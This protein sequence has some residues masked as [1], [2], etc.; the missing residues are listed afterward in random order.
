MP[1]LSCTLPLPEISSKCS[2]PSK[3]L[4]VT[5]NTTN[6][7]S[8]PKKHLSKR[9]K[10]RG[11]MLQLDSHD[12]QVAHRREMS[13][14]PYPDFMS[15]SNDSLHSNIANSPEIRCPLCDDIIPARYLG[16]HLHDDHAKRASEL[17]IVAGN[18]VCLA[19]K[20][21][22]CVYRESKRSRHWHCLCGR[23]LARFRQAQHHIPR[24]TLAQEAPLS[25]CAPLLNLLA[26]ARQIDSGLP[27]STPTPSHHA[28]QP[29]SPLTAQISPVAGTFAP[30]ENV[31]PPIEYDTSSHLSDCSA[32]E[33]M[34]AGVYSA[35]SV[36]SLP[37][38]SWNI[39]STPLTSSIQP[40]DDTSTKSCFDL[41][42]EPEFICL[43]EMSR[44]SLVEVHGH[45][46]TNKTSHVQLEYKGQ[47]EIKSEY[48]SNR[49]ER[50]FSSPPPLAVFPPPPQPQAQYIPHDLPALTHSHA[51]YVPTDQQD[52][53]MLQSSTETFKVDLMLWIN[54]T[55]KQQH[56]QQ[57]QFPKTRTWTVPITVSQT[58]IVENV[59]AYVARLVK[60]SSSTHQAGVS[61]SQ[62]SFLHTPP[63]SPA[64]GQFPAI[65]TSSM[66]PDVQIWKWNSEQP[67]LLDA[68]CCILQAGV[69]RGQWLLATVLTF[70]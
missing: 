23:N 66:P 33:E 17:L 70:C 29:L 34:F 8:N 7:R 4:Q 11:Q 45:S 12:P 65:G 50:I 20:W 26:T 49:N 3:T 22:P 36:V 57:Q 60:F 62:S 30:P 52:L 5:E 58:T 1:A 39:S 68:G 64:Y 61:S 31:P 63:A 21:Y 25:A 56:Q 59:R 15:A 27:L 42:D 40:A 46:M 2:N 13:W 67:E 35:G 44:T 48:I 24:C 41:A 51:T 16:A 32:G 10:L 43:P 47:G 9:L 18:K 6:E 14:I 38:A 19:C 55:L 69:R 54:V 37:N 28:Y 53:T